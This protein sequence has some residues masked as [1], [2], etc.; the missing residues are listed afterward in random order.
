MEENMIGESTSLHRDKEEIEVKK[1]NFWTFW[2]TINTI[3]DVHWAGVTE[4]SASC[5]EFANS[6]Y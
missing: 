4:T 3:K 5:I 1:I 6:D 2:T